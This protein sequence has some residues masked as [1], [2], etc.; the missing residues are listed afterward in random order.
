MKILFFSD[1][2]GDK[3]ALEILRNKAKES[4][5]LVCAGDFTQMERNI[6]DIMSY[7]NSFNKTILMIHGNHE[8]EHRVK[9]LCKA[10]KNIIFLHKGIYTVGDYIFMGYGGGGFASEDPRFQKVAGF[11]KKEAENKKR[12]ILVTHGP[13]YGTSLDRINSQYIGNKTYREFIE[14]TKPH[15]AV[16]GHIHETA[17]KTD[18]IGRT[19]LINPGKYGAF[20]EI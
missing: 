1:T 11:F 13:P 15:L 6:E 4:D 2:H 5:G 17:G 3:K 14:S 8:D 20:V 18:K 12:I 19:L 9:E 16:S 10:H 7:L